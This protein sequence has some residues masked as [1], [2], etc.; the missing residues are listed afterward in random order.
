M[1]RR[2]KSKDS[3][4]IKQN[5]ALPDQSF[6]IEAKK[7]HFHR[8]IIL[9]LAHADQRMLHGCLK[10]PTKQKIGGDFDQKFDHVLYFSSA[11]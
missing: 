3:F 9:F 4:K 1:Y 8:P 7:S 5:V 2:I 6:V 10:S 11:D